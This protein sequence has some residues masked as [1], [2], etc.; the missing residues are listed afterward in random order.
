MTTPTHSALRGVPL[1]A[2]CDDHALD[3]IAA[4][5]TEFECPPHHVLVE[6][7]QPGTGLFI[8]EE[9]SVEV[10]L[11]GGRVA[12]RGPGQFIGELAL[13]TDSPRTARVSCGS[14]VRGLAINRRDFVRL[15]EE[16]PEIAVPMAVELARRIAEEVAY[17]MEH[18]HG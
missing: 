7:G 2:G 1:F 16:H 9:G 8:I 3:H 11:P 18:Q 14:D 10:L 5:A 17:D 4:M 13:L 6:V 12:T 15:L